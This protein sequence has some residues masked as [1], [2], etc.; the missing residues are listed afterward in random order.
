VRRG[1][2]RVPTTVRCWRKEQS[3]MR[4][5]DEGMKEAPRM[6]EARCSVNEVACFE[7]GTDNHILDY[8]GERPRSE[9]ELHIGKADL[10]ILENLLCGSRILYRR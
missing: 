9:S 8:K 3:E 5:V 7:V 4:Q 6:Y 1:E 10:T 2:R